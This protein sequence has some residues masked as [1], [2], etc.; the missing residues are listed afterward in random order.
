MA[1]DLQGF[2]VEVTRKAAEDLIAAVEGLPAEKRAWRPLEKGRSAADQAAECAIL[3]GSTAKI[4]WEREWDRDF[5]FEQYERDRAELA[6]DWEAVKAVL[7]ENTEKVIA[8]IEGFPPE[9][10]AGE[11]AAPWGPMPFTRVLSYPYW[12]MSYHEGQV[13]YIASLQ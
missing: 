7:R 6:R 4:L 2:L 12:N 13:N 3:N 9:E 8:A 5:S 11:V 1:G 10:M